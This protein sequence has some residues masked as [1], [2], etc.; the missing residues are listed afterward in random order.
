[1]NMPG[2]TAE[3][4]LYKTSGRYQSEATRSFGRSGTGEVLPM[5]EFLAS[6]PLSQNLVFPLRGFPIIISRERAVGMEKSCIATIDGGQ[7][8][9]VP[10]PNAPICWKVP[11]PPPTARWW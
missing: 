3:A 8:C 10:G 6:S 5:Q 2:F 1:M 11:P 7:W 9:C 4:S